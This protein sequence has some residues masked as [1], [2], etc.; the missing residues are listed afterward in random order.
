M[1]P[2]SPGLRGRQTLGGDQVAGMPTKFAAELFDR[3]FDLVAADC[4]GTHCVVSLA[5][6]IDEDRMAVAVRL[7]LDA[8][9]ILGCRWVEH[10]FR[11]SWHRRDDL[12]A[13]EVYEV[14]ERSNCQGDLEDFLWSAPHAPVRVL[15]LCGD[16]E[17]LCI[18]LDHRAGDGQALKEYAYL[19]ADIYNRLGDDP[20][21]SSDAQ[22][23]RQPGNAA[24]QPTLR[25]P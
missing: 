25:G 5:G 22:P 18:K 12:D 8:E 20:D 23:A 14:R 10:W 7:R 19:L 15:L 21:V 11:P 13:L 24:C 9:P 4:T 1:I 6:R 3:V 16:S 2:R 17:W